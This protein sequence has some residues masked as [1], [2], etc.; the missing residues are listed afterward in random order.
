M[1]GATFGVDVILEATPEREVKRRMDWTEPH[2]EEGSWHL[3]MQSAG[4]DE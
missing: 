2:L 1:S 4:D 3:V